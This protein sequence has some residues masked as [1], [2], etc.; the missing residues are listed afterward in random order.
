MSIQL[1]NT[2]DR[3]GKRD[4]WDKDMKD[5]REQLEL[6][7]LLELEDMEESMELMVLV[8]I[9]ADFHQQ[10]LQHHR[11]DGH[12]LKSMKKNHRLA[13]NHFN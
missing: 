8:D 2:R 13:L 6:M 5:K 4:K 11:L 10:S 9:L 3:L 1:G 7:E 12:R